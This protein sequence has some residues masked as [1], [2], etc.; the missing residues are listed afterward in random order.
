MAGG[1]ANENEDLVKR[2]PHCSQLVKSGRK[3]LA[4]RMGLSGWTPGLPMLPLEKQG[5]ATNDF[6][7]ALWATICPGELRRAQGSSDRPL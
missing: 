5:E 6:Q 1:G 3:G 7:F 2:T 4:L